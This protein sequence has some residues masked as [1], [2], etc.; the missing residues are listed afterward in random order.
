MG[1]ASFY[2]VHDFRDR[3]AGGG[4]EEM[5]VIGHDDEGVEFVVG[6]GSVVLEV[7]RKSSALG[8]RRKR[9]R[10][11]RVLVVTK[12]VPS[13]AVRAGVAMRGV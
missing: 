9:S 2:E 7:S 10:R 6:L 4:E 5:D 1:E 3:G 13:A 11:S 8:G 12:K